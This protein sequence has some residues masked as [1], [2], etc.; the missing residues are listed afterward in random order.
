VRKEDEKT[1]PEKAGRQQRIVMK[2]SAGYH[3]SLEEF[4]KLGYPVASSYPIATK[5]STCCKTQ[6]IG[7]LITWR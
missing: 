4:V 1:K 5:S 7:W 6:R 3:A 2:I